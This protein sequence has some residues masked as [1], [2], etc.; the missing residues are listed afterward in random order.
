VIKVSNLSK[1]FKLNRKQRREHGDGQ[2]NRKTLR[3]VDSISFECQPG[4]VFCL[5]GPNG[6]GK[7]TTLRIISTMLKP[8]EGSV[9]VANF[10]TLENPKEVRR[11]IGFMTAQT[12]LYDRL[13]PTEM[14]QYIADLYGMQAS[15][16]EERKNRIFSMLDMHSFADRRIARL[17]SG[18]KQK[19][20][21][22]R[23]IIHDPSVVVFD[24]PTTGLDIMTARRIIE[25]IRSC[26]EEG[27]TVI[28][29]TH[30]MSELRLL[31]DDLAIIHGG[32]LYFQGTT[33]QFEAEMKSD[34]YEDEFVRLVGGA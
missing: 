9:T 7:T 33:E 19:T 27:K 18:M 34:S 22:A 6:A 3:A 23:T 24:E 4:R 28:F 32:K 13:T 21:I 26:R 25:L 11:N 29:S 8:T 2:M 30:H 31:C 1:D 12:A 16:F 17:S 14:V 5:I 10:D 15:H 20:S